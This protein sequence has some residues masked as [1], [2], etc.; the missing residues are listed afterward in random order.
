MCSPLISKFYELLS[1]SCHKSNTLLRL[2]RG[3]KKKELCLSLGAKHFLDYS[4][5]DF[6]DSAR[7]L[8]SGLGVH[9]VVCTAN[10]AKAY[11]QSLQMLRPLGTLVCVGIPSVPFNLPATP[12]DMIIKGEI[13]VICFNPFELL[14]L[15]RSIGNCML[16]AFSGLTIVGNSA[17]TALEMDELLSMAVAGDVEAHI[18]VFGLHEINSVLEDLEKSE[19]EGRVVLKIP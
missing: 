16:I 1:L 14:S 3:P 4:E 11:E 12:L 13:S 6:V 7:I 18:K 19:V 15:T 10:S 17:G 9:G 5:V 2:F 8:T